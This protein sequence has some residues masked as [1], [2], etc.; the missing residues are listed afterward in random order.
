MESAVNFGAWSLVPLIFAL[1][2]AF[3]TRSAIFSLFA[4]C[5][6]GV[7]MMGYDP[8]ATLLGLDPAG[9]LVKLIAAS[10]D[11]EFIRICVIII[12]IGILF[13]L[14][15]RAG[16]LVAFAEK[17]SKTGTSPKKVKFTTWLLGFFIVDDYLL[18]WG[19]GG[20]RRFTLC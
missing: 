16:V 4:G 11:G 20:L 5:L 19:G 7:M 2:I 8:Q 3:W 17:V 18:Q 15:K 1:V 6:I 13:E 14:F 10:L 12:F 9:G